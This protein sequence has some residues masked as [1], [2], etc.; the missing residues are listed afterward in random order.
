MRPLLL[1]A[2]SATALAARPTAGPTLTPCDTCVHVKAEIALPEAITPDRFL[3]AVLDLHP[4]ESARCLAQPLISHNEIL[5]RTGSPPCMDALEITAGM[6]GV[7][8]RVLI[9][10]TCLK[11]ATPDEVVAEWTLVGEQLDG[12]CQFGGPYAN[13]LAAACREGAVFT[14]HNH[15]YWVLS[16][17]GRLVT[18]NAA[19]D[20]GGDV[21]D[22]LVKM[23]CPGA[24]ARAVAFDRWIGPEQP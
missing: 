15:G 24:I 5:G 6:M 20:P 22:T 9:S 18:W 16:N 12:D 7:A 3:R 19:F 13:R 8:P 2:L 10:R 23:G 21:P 11:S 14:P 17:E 1:L 4:K